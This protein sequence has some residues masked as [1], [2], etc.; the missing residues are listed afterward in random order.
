MEWRHLESFAFGDSSELAD[1]LLA[2][3][4]DGKKR[5]TCWAVA[6]GMKGAE[7]GK[8]MVALDGAGRPRAVLRTLELTQHRYDQVDEAFAFDEGEGDRSLAFWRGA[9]ALLYPAEALPAGHDAVVRT[10]QAGQGDP[11]GSAV[12]GLIFAATSIGR[13][14]S[15]PRYA[16]RNIR[17]A[18]SITS[19]MR[20]AD[21]AG[22]AWKM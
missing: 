8:C 9:S 16:A 17:I 10:L 19:R 2:L 11:V 1:E 14:A 15:L 18:L 13:P 3:V 21:G 12:A 7:I 20:S 6:E 4:L 22:E 5:A